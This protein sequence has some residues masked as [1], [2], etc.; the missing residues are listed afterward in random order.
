MILD[1][2]ENAE[3]YFALHPLFP[4]AFAALRRLAA[5]TPPPGR[6]P[7]A[8]IAATPPGGKEASAHTLQSVSRT[9]LPGDAPGATVIVETREG[10]GR[11]Q[12]PLEA[13][14]RFMDIQ[15]TLSGE[16][17]IGWRATAECARPPAPYDTERDIV[18]FADAPSVWLPVPPG[19]F[20]IFFPDDA[21]APLGGRGLLRKLI[22]KVPV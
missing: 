16:E 18:F 8:S 5:E 21:H 17:E 6:Y 1:R 4:A 2:F 11:A 10:R 22:A 14:R 7:I 15:L 3:R 13:H 20:A 12:S 19:H 9:A